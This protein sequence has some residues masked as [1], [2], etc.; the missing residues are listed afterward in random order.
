MANIFNIQKINDGPRNVTI[1][2]YLES[3]GVAGE[4]VDG[5]LVDASTLVPVPTTLRLT[6]ISYDLSGFEA[7]LS[8]EA[9]ADDPLVS[10]SL[11]EDVDFARFG[12][13][14]NPKSAGVTGDI[15]LTTSGFTIATDRGYIVL[16][17]TKQ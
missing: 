7:M 10:L 3:D 16:E 12:G 4:I 14:P 1:K 5:V 9:T 8:W 17:F 15:L 2:A 11:Q 6:H 13:I